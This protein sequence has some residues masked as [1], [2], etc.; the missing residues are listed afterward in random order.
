MKKLVVG[1]QSWVQR[2]VAKVGEKALNCG[3][4]VDPVKVE[5]EVEVVPSESELKQMAS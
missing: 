4:H 5:P 2:K 1:G 3:N